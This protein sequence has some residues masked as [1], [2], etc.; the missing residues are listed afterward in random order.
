MQAASYRAESMF[1]LQVVTVYWTRYGGYN[2][3]EQYKNKWFVLTWREK[4]AVSK[5][6]AL[7]GL[8]TWGERW[9]LVN[10]YIAGRALLFLRSELNVFSTIVVSAPQTQDKGLS[11]GYRTSTWTF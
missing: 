3:I 6:R 9:S 5:M 7:L 4:S 11:G 10:V 1:L 2:E 8:G